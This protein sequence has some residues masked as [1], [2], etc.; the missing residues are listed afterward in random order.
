MA[1]LAVAAADQAIPV[2][3]EMFRQHRQRKA[4][5]AAIRNMLDLFLPPAGQQEEAAVDTL[6][7]D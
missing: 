2:H 3:R 1:G 5:M 7:L 4:M 6:P